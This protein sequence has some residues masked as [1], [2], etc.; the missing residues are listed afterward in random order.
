MS[1][2]SSKLSDQNAINRLT[3][4]WAL[5]ESGI[6]GIMHALKIPFTGLVVGGISIILVSLICNL[7]KNS[8]GALLQA[9]MIVLAIKLAISPHS[10]FTAYIAV[11]FQALSG[12]L[13][14]GHIRHRFTAVMLM[15]II[16]MLESAF[17]KLLVL[18]IF[19][20]KTFWEAIDTFGAWVVS[21][22]GF[23]LS[24]ESSSILIGLYVGMYLFTGIMLG[25]FLNQ[26]LKDILELR[27]DPA[28]KIVILRSDAEKIF[29]NSKKKNRF[30]KTLITLLVIVFIVVMILLQYKFEDYK[31]IYFLLRVTLVFTVWFGLIN[32]FIIK[33]MKVALNPQ[34]TGLG[35]QMQDSLNLFPYLRWI[36][37]KSWEEAKNSSGSGYKEFTKR[38]ILYSLNFEIQND[39][40]HT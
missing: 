23:V 3:A 29:L 14:Y 12:W 39:D 22:V 21:Q 15:S 26:F 7:S 28:Y 20:G 9:L 36:I 2:T 35:S 31:L 27:E 19:Y 37:K 33:R 30:S 32:P 8:R 5:S 24:V 4:L 17:Q 34:K 11:A 18:T 25:I 6:G 1:E 13:I 10:S 16:C 38:L 40:I